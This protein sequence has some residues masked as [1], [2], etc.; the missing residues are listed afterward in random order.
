MSWDSMVLPLSL[1]A[2]KGKAWQGQKRV[3]EAPVEMNHTQN[4]ELAHLQPPE[5]QCVS[6]PAS[7]KGALGTILGMCSG[8]G[9]LH[10]PLVGVDQRAPGKWAELRHNVWWSGVKR[11]AME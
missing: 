7:Q 9:T 1:A 5:L 2:G 8:A 11:K 6:F 10:V 4:A 3:W